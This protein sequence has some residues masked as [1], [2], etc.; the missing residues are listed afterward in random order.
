M[1][2][3]HVYPYRILADEAFADFASSKRITRAS[4]NAC[5]CIAITDKDEH[6]FMTEERYNRWKFGRTYEMDGVIYH[7]GER[8][9]ERTE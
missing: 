1:I 4:K 9:A 2:Y 3:A 7:S 6:H 5:E 8:L